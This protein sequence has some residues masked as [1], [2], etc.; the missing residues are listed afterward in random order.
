MN[1]SRTLQQGVT[2]IEFTLVLVVFGLLLGGVL[3]TTEII[4][5]AK[6]KSLADR[7]HS[8]EFA[9]FTFIDRYGGVA[10]TVSN[11]Q[12]YLPEA[13]APTR[14]GYMDLDLVRDKRSKWTFQ[15]LVVAGLLRCANCTGGA[16]AEENS[17]A[18]SPANT[19]GGF[20]EIRW[21]ENS[22]FEHVAYPRTL[23]GTDRV[24]DYS[25]RNILYTGGGIPSNVLAELDRKIDDGAPNK[26]KLRFGGQRGEEGNYAV[27]TTAT[28]T[29]MDLPANMKWRPVP[30]ARNCGAAIFL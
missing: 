19:Y 13:Q 22:G 18:N 10:G 30:V 24:L 25:E 9:W 5:N 11:I 1:R 7:I 29:R 6:V 20:Y 8:I 16:V 23:D 28:N 2:L 12:D 15:N 17:L 3:K 4:N 14:P 21:G 27:C 26:A